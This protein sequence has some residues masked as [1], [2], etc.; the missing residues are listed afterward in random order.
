MKAPDPERL[1]IVVHEVRS[2]V[3]ALDALATAAAT[4][5][6]PEL[7]R[8]MVDLGVAAA[9][10]VARLVS[11]PDLVSLRLEPVDLAALAATFSRQDVSVEIDGPATVDGDATR[12]R[13]VLS[14]LVANALRHGT[15][16][17]I[18]VHTSNG[19]V[20]VSVADDGPGIASGVDPFARGASG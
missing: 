18:E 7:I 2:P 17:A 16:A 8:R 19:R 11:D 3:A 15:R 1:R 12:L 20:V 13:Q 6:D 9:R 10:D 14:N 5:D 4:T